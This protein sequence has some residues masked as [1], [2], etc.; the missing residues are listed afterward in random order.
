MPTKPSKYWEDRS[1]KI[2][3]SAEESSAGLLEKL[4]QQYRIAKDTIEGDIAKWYVRYSKN[5]KIS[6]ADAKIALS[7]RELK[8]LQW[9]IKTY[10]DR[11]KENSKTGKWVK[12]L[13]RASTRAHISR[14]E[15][16]L[17]QINAQLGILS[18]SEE[19]GLTSL[20][21][22]VY[23]DSYY[24]S[25]YDISIGT[26][27]GVS[28]SR[29][30]KGRLSKVISRPWTA[31]DVVFSKR[32][33]DDQDK[34]LAILENELSQ[35]IILGSQPSKT[36]SVVS[37]RLG[38]SYRNA[39]RLV[40][41]ESAYFCELATK[42]SYESLSVDKFQIIATLDNRTSEICQEMDGKILPVKDLVPGVTAPPFHPNCRST[43]IPYF[44]NNY[45]KRIARSARGNA[46]YVPSDMTYNAWKKKYVK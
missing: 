22:K 42:D 41:T 26:N 5:E 12:Q 45:G 34:L 19:D 31:D 32:I 33:W 17:L 4:K 14:L 20:V 35:N 10:I 38:V 11:G 29:I 18:S 36:I 40:N 43:T 28:L 27:V 25:A 9:D 13:E 30:D 23:Q 3:R 8:E 21:G 44:D 37:E 39:S 15:A 2:V 7:A 46:E 24:R 6:L 1:E 16:L